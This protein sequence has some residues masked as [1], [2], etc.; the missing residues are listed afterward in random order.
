MKHLKPYNYILSILLTLS[1]IY[2]VTTHSVSAQRAEQT[3]EELID[4]E[5]EEHL[6]T[7]LPLDLEFKN[8]RDQTVKL[9]DYFGNDKPVILTLVYFRCPMLCGLLLNGMLEGLKEL[10]MNP[11]EEFE[12]VTISFDPLETPALAQRKKQNMLKEYGRVGADK[13]WHFLTGRENNIK[14]L[15]ETVG[16][17]YTFVEERNEYAHAAAIFI[18]TPDGRISRYLYGIQYDAQTLRLSLVE[19]SNGEIGNTLDQIM[20]YCYHYDPNSRRYAPVAMNIMRAG[21]ILTVI[22]LGTVLSVFWIRE[23]RRK[24]ATVEENGDKQV[25]S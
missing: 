22:I 5:I 12:I 21:G 9:K 1:S 24:K 20:L 4:V 17:K 19:A 16:F 13:G 3:P 11:G 14:R 7:S 25:N 2:G 23:S 15:T 6:N 10:K 8:E 18:C